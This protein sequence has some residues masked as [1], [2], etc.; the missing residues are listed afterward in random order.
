MSWIA[1]AVTGA[2]VTAS[3]AQ[4]DAAERSVYGLRVNVTSM[5]CEYCRTT[6]M[7]GPECCPNC[8]GPYSDRSPTLTDISITENTVRNLGRKR[9]GLAI[10]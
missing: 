3:K 4:A 10:K 9:G 8:G 1:A 6:N 5:T 7:V 2:A